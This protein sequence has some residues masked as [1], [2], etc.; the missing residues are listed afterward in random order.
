[1]GHSSQ[2]ACLPHCPAAA[3]VGRPHVPPLKNKV[4]HF[5]AWALKGKAPVTVDVARREDPEAAPEVSIQQ[6]KQ[7][8]GEVVETMKSVRT[9]LDSQADRSERLLEL[10]GDLPDTLRSLPDQ[11]RT[12]TGVLKAIE[13]HLDNQDHTTR[14]LTEAI[15]GLAT[16]S[17][18]QQRSLAALDTHLAQG[19]ES[20]T[21]LN[22][23]VAALTT[24]LDGVQDSNAATRASMNAVVEQTRVN[25][26]RIREMFQKS[27]KMNTM[28]VILCLALATGALALGG[29]MAVLV[30]KVVQ[31]PATPA[32]SA[33]VAPAAPRVAEQGSMSAPTSTPTDAPTLSSELATF[34]ATDL[35]ANAY[36][37]QPAPT[38]EAASDDISADDGLI[39]EVGPPAQTP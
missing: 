6:L 29:Y 34:T 25:D 17:A 39:D 35:S 3:S 10:L 31:N 9:H 8:Y 23:G 2:A 18:H 19:H 4:G 36:R 28:M 30:S 13:T 24:T 5:F 21:Q 11:A 12:Q 33:A 1:M 7:G 38:A 26:E 32:T 37:V 15:T 16:A 14:Q 20:R 27:Q 22:Q